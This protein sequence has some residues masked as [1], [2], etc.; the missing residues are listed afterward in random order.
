VSSHR[1]QLL[2]ELGH[3]VR[4]NQRATDLVDEL[5]AELMGVN[6][7]DGRCL[8][9]LE[10]EGRMSAGEL[11][12]SSGLT[13]GAITGVIDRLE[14]AGYARRAADPADR[15]RVL[16]EPT[17]RAREVGWELFG[18][19]AEQVEPR[20]AKY[21]DE[22]LEL[23]IEFQRQGREFQEEHAQWLRERLAAKG[24]ERPRRG[25]RTAP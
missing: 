6:R 15:R 23:L 12:R 20:L 2:E 14:R 1:S 10:Q 9:L 5:V 8:D 22:Q 7:T 11:A 3:V 4:A 18:R 24:R 19:L 17:E 13:T 21:S 16:V 25:S